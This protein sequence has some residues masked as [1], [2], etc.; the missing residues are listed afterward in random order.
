[1]ISDGVAYT[2]ADVMKGTLD[3]GTAVGN[4]IECPASGKTGT[5]EEQADAWFVG[6]TPDVATAVWTGHANDRTPVPVYGADL[7]VPI[8]RDY[9]EAYIAETANCDDYPEPKDP[10]E[11]S[12][13]ASDQTISS[14]SYYTP[15]T[16]PTTTTTPADAAAPVDGVDADGDGYPEAAPAPGADQDAGPP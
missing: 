16:E 5:T 15:S 2:V 4:D 9:M 12:S 3:Y 10:A 7:S 1:M 6:Y 13:F 8:W 14:S 11:L